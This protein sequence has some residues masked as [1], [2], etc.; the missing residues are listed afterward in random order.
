MVLVMWWDLNWSLFLAM[1]IMSCN[2]WLLLNPC[3]MKK[4]LILLD[5]LVNTTSF[6]FPCFMIF[7]HLMCF[8]IV[9]CISLPYIIL[10]QLGCLIIENELVFSSDH[11]FRV[12]SK[13]TCSRVSSRVTHSKVTC[14]N[15]SSKVSS[16]V[17]CS[18]VKI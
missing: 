18:R 17:T 15:V 4:L 13:F 7:C 6:L 3:V 16:R 9:M 2:M 1:Q 12:S 5:L 14:S 10:T 8:F 11:S